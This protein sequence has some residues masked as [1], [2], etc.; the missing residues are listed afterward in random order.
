MDR[1]HLD[2][3]SALVPDGIQSPILPGE[4]GDEMV[5]A[6]K[7]SP[8]G[9]GTWACYYLAAGALLLAAALPAACEPAPHAAF[10]GDTAP[11]SRA[12][13]LDTAP[14]NAERVGRAA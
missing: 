9:H 13:P 7:G 3:R 10:H 1:R 8:R 6:N 4:R 12:R 2:K 11:G 14:A 5:R